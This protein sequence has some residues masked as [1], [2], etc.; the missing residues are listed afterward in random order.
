M[1]TNSTAICPVC[2]KEF[3]QNDR[4]KFFCNRICSNKSRRVEKISPKI[5]SLEERFWAKVDRSNG[6]D[7]CWEWQGSKS[8]GYGLFSIDRIAHKASRVAYTFTKGPITDGLFVLHSCDNP[9]CCNP[10]HLRLG[11]Y[12]DNTDDKM[13]RGRARSGIG[14]RHGSAKLTE[15]EVREIYRN[16]SSGF[17]NISQLA[18]R[19]N[20]DFST[21]H[22][23]VT[24]ESWKHLQLPPFNIKEVVARNHTKQK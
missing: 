12:R 5:I 13:K 18:T 15:N 24:G 11:T 6:P 14:E 3:R 1:P 4:N 19:F 20:M 17:E 23:I 22:S 7:A 21:I 2:Q 8:G 10:E 9:P 16:Y